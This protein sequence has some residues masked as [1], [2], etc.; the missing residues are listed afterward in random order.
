MESGSTQR[1]IRQIPNQQQQQF[2]VV[3]PSK[4]QINVPP[5][6]FFRLQQ[7]GE[8]MALLSYNL[9][10][11]SNF[12]Q[13]I[14]TA[15]DGST[16]VVNSV[17]SIS[18]LS[19]SDLD[20]LVQ[21]GEVIQQDLMYVKFEIAK[22]RASPVIVT[23]PSQGKVS[24]SIPYTP[25]PQQQTQQVNSPSNNYSTSYNNS[26]S[27]LQSQALISVQT[28]QNNVLSNRVSY[29]NAD[30]T[31]VSLP[32]NL[33]VGSSGTPTYVNLTS[34][35]MVK[36]QTKRK[37]VGEPSLFCHNCK[38][39]ETPEWRRGPNGAKTLCNACGIR[40]RIS[41][42]QSGVSSRNSRAN[43]HHNNNL[44][45]LNNL[46]NLTNLTNLGNL[47]SLTNLSSFNNLSN[48]TNLTNLNNLNNSLNNINNLSTLNNLNNLN[49]LNTLN[50][51]NSLN[52]I[53]NINSISNNL[54]NLNNINNNS[55]LNFAHDPSSSSLLQPT[56]P[57]QLQVQLPLSLPLQ[58]IQSPSCSRNSNNAP[59]LYP[60]GQVL[61]NSVSLSNTPQVTPEASNIA[62]SPSH[63]PTT[64]F[65][66]TQ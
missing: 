6:N 3:D 20:K 66:P 10:V 35:T 48:L 43:H 22:R 16:N 27:N 50:T 52:N 26:N 24:I 45:N 57:N 40:W 39:R 56:I 55:H 38:T 58:S 41:Q 42:D 18:N 29:H 32:D 65:T 36:T 13:S 21:I 25:P 14:T 2:I 54:N 4:D 31:N 8:Q 46:S 34:E 62:T 53:N 64:P 11:S 17:T 49:T 51:L 63:S 30:L 47:N 23:T 28:N 9:L 5:P 33:V 19:T 60:I 1:I 61:S 44:N 59:S 7:S 12:S 15:A 37:R